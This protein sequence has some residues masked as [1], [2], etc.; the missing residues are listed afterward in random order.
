MEKQIYSIRLKKDFST[1][2]KFFDI[3][4]KSKKSSKPKNI[5]GQVKKFKFRKIF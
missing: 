1:E 3:F 2:Q 4:K 5:L